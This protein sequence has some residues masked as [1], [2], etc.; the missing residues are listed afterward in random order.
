MWNPAAIN[1]TLQNRVADAIANGMSGISHTRD[2]L[3]D[4]D[5]LLRRACQAAA[6]NTTE[7]KMISPH[8]PYI[9]RG[10]RRGQC[11]MINSSVKKLKKIAA[12]LV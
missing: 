11:A 1:E 8:Q 12:D 3:S 9:D 7:Q 5:D 2:A 4:A 6:M 10:T